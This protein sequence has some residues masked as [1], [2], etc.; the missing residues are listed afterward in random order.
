[1]KEKIKLI[2]LII[3]FILFLICIN[4]FMKNKTDSIIDRSKVLEQEKNSTIN[5]NEI[6]EVVEENFDEEVL[7]SD[8][9]VLI[10]FYATWCEP[11]KQLSP[12]IDIVSS[13]I[14]DVKFV[15]IDVDKN[16]ELSYK[17]QIQYMPTLIVIENGNEI[18]RSVGL[19]NKD[20]IKKLI[21]K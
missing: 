6:I 16:K 18:N 4:T 8:K 7:N 10:D 20:S 11:C 2:V 17:Y 1:M 21:G 19:I 13:E 9:K 14:E 3:I 5:K 12:I 15:R